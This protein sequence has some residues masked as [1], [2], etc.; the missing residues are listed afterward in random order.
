MPLCAEIESNFAIF[1]FAGGCEKL[2]KKIKKSSNPQIR[3]QPPLASGKD[4]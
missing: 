2:R 3:A 1:V 4:N